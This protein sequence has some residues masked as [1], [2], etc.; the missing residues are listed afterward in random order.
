M[1]DATS[2]IAAL[3]SFLFIIVMLGIM[4]VYRHKQRD[5]II[6]QSHER[7]D[8][9]A[10]KW[11]ESRRAL[12]A[13]QQEDMRMR[14]NQERA[15]RTPMTPPIDYRTR[16]R[17]MAAESGHDPATSYMFIYATPVDVEGC[18]REGHK[19]F[20]DAPAC[21]TPSHSSHDSGSSSSSSSSCGSSP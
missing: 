21:P 10:K 20:S 1:G 13:K 7:V 11:R 2:A 9:A 16:N 5:Q 12:H 14:V 18:A 8:A 4:L 17:R 6:A 15:P 19:A 3:L